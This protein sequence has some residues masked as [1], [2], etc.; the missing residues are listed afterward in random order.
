MSAELLDIQPRELKFIFELK[1]QCSCS[2]RLVN[3]SSKHVAFKVKT[4]SPKKY[5]V[6]PNTGIIEPKSS[7]DFT[8]T[9]QAQKVAPS[10]M[11]CK[12]KFLVQST[13][14][15]AG[16]TEEDI[17]SSMFFKDDGRYIEENKMKVIL[18]SPPNSPVLSPMNGTLKPIPNYDALILKDPVLREVESFAPHQTVAEEVELKMKSN[19]RVKPAKDVEYKTLKAAREP[20]KDAEYITMKGEEPEKDAD[21]KRMKGMEEPQK[22][23]EG[24]T[25]K[26]VEEPEKDAEHKMMNDIGESE[27]DVERETGNDVG[28]PEK[29]VVYKTFTDLEVPSKDVECK[30]IKD[31]QPLA[32]Y[33]DHKAAKDLEELEKDVE[34]KTTKDV[35][36]L[37]LNKNIEEIT[38]K[39]NELESKLNE[40]EITI[41]K[42]TEER[43][44]AAQERES[45]QQELASLRSKKS[46]R[47]VQVG[48]PFLFVCMVALVSVVLGYLLHG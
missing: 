9:M 2:I 42:L 39:L 7:C 1:K 8:V 22:D 14:V 5:C 31:V 38:S 19:E 34:Y 30:I 28:E 37:K 6:R 12:D 35:E 11:I 15:P 16:T 45:L 17:T 41:S 48:F 27:K 36:E 21:Y 46:F 47:K 24:K 29:D 20:E 44:W 25:R 3:K 13:A 43:R 4:T 40:A 10:D 18:I 33:V 26:G 23:V 32:N